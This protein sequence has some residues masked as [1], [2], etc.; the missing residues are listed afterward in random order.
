[1]DQAI[2]TT[3]ASP[4]VELRQYQLKPGKRDVLI[5]L[6]ES[7]FVA[8]Q[9]ATGSRLHGEFRDALDPD[10][11]VWL[12]GFRDMQDRERAL[13]TFYE[14]PV[15]KANSAAANATM[16]DVS[17]V[18]LLEPVD[19]PGFS[20]ARRMTSLMVATIYSLQAPAD[21]AFIRFFDDK[22]RPVLTEAG[23]PPVAM[24]RTLDA[25]NNFP[26]LPVREGEHA[27][28]WFAAFAT[29][30]EYQR[31]VMRL[32]GSKSWSAIEAELATRFKSPAVRLELE[33]T[34]ESITRNAQPFSYSLDHTGDVHD[35]DFITG[36][37]IL[38]NRR[39]LARG[40]GKKELDHFPARSRGYVFMGG[41]TNADEV[42]FPTKG[43]S[44]TTFRHFDLEKRQWSIYWVNNR[45]G[46][47]QAPVV[48][49][50]EGDIG[51]FYGEDVDEGRPVKVVFKWTKVG[52]NAARW[53]Q[54][55][56]YDGGR[57]W[58]TNWMNELWR[59]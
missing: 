46:K 1:M 50:F 28:V 22:V 45:D 3:Q 37:W 4:V 40:V 44:G 20:L 27:F 18:L 34:S 53:E 13:R 39:L 23:A 32:L 6:F 49:G 42:E 24:L 17:N 58:E 29:R 31:Y 16:V 10:R 54:S 7:R 59:E 12:R 48:G 25:A 15:W 38:E 41:V 52:P 51:L 5:D 56:S 8:G 30:N 47:M 43:W 26:K 11:F 19:R 57:T 9:E 21:A 35:F 2:V 55:F 33:P 36:N 14:G